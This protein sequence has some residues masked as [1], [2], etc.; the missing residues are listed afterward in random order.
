MAT[1]IAKYTANLNGAVEIASPTDGA[2]DLYYEPTKDTRFLLHVHNGSTTSHVD[3]TVEAGDYYR[4]EILG[5][6]NDLKEEAIGAGETHILGPLESSRFLDEDGKVQ[7]V[8]S[9]TDG[10]TITEVEVSVIEVSYE[11]E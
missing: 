9:T 2:N 10:A 7:V 8:V 3:V 5:S 6:D 1:E 11:E 4:D